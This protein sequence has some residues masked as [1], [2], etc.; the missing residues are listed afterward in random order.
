MRSVRDDLEALTTEA[1]SDVE[2]RAHPMWLPGVKYTMITAIEGCVDMAQHLCSSEG[3][4]PPSDNGDAIRVLARHG[5]L[6]GAPAE[7]MV[8]AVGFRNV[9]VHEYV[10]VDDRIVRS[11]LTDLSDLD[12]F[13]VAVAAWMQR[14]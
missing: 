14:A 9:L 1:T 2:S 10:A 7:R 6:D 4:G 12:E 13:L 8:L 5:V 3:W 11:R